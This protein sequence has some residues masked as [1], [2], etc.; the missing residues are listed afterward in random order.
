MD[1]ITKKERETIFGDLVKYYQFCKKDRRNHIMNAIVALKRCCSDKERN[2][3]KISLQEKKNSYGY[4]KRMKVV[5]FLLKGNLS[6][7]ITQEEKKQAIDDLIFHYG[8]R[9]KTALFHIKSAE[10]AI[11]RIE[12]VKSNDRELRIEKIKNLL[13]EDREEYVIYQS[14][15][16]IVE[17]LKNEITHET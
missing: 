11:K 3:I 17:S 4:Y 15:M 6:D 5:A 16:K 12:D 14:K 10:N 13:L 8:C 9:I 7:F 1:T 2:A